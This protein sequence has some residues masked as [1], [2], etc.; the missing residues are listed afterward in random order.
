MNR[1]TFWACTW[2]MQLDRIP[3]YGRV[4]MYTKPGG[5][6]YEL[7]EMPCKWVWQRKGCWGMNFLDRINLFWR[8]FD[9][10]ERRQSTKR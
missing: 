4:Y 8:Y 3:R 7:D 2:V 10:L 5:G 1:L 9:E 6:H